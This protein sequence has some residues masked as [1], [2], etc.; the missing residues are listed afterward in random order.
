ML[1]LMLL[2]FSSSPHY[3][4]QGVE[5]RSEMQP[6][7]KTT[8]I[9]NLSTAAAAMSLLASLGPTADGVDVNQGQGKD[10]ALPFKKNKT[11]NVDKPGE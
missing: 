9:A 1:G 3:S 10:A 2:T 7:W 11:I 4:L 5:K 6:R 8:L